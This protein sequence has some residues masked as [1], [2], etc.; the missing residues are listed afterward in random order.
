MHDLIHAVA[1]QWLLYKW[2]ALKGFTELDFGLT[3]KLGGGTVYVPADALA[4]WQRQWR[5]LQ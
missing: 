5:Q 4:R 3:I 1:G 2:D